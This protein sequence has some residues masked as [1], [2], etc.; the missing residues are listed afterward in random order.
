MSSFQDCTSVIRVLNSGVVSLRQA[1]HQFL[2]YSGEYWVLLWLGGWEHQYG[3]TMFLFLVVGWIL[4]SFLAVN[5][6][7]TP[8]NWWISLFSKAIKM[9]QVSEKKNKKPTTLNEDCSRSVCWL[10]QMGP[11]YWK[12]FTPNM[13][14]APGCFFSFLLEGDGCSECSLTSLKLRWRGEDSERTGRPQCPHWTQ[15]NWRAFMSQELFFTDSQQT[16][17][18]EDL[19]SWCFCIYGFELH[20]EFLYVVVSCNL[21]VWFWRKVIWG[22]N[23]FF[24]L[25]KAVGMQKGE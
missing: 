13:N 6:S 17:A 18:R 21:T 25:C 3:E 7:D 20:Q 12:N 4:T 10:E 2:S 11:H 19:V 5:I 9:S 23:D 15:G 16:E 8:N 24:L 22:L 1:P 14:I